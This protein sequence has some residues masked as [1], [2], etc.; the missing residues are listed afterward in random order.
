MKNILLTIVIAL[1][2]SSCS[3]LI[4]KFV[5]KKEGK[6]CTEPACME[7]DKFFWDNFHA[8]NYDSIPRILELLKQSY[9]KNPTDY[10]LAAHIAFTH[11]WAIAEEKKATVSSAQVIDHAS[12]ARQ[13]FKEAFELGPKKDWRLYGF[14]ASFMMIE[15]SIH[16]NDRQATEGYFEM[17]KAVKRYPEF[18]LF[19]KAYSIMDGRRKEA[20]EDLWK[21]LDVCACEKVDRKNLDYRK[22]QGLKEVES[23]MSTCWNNWIAPHNLEGF[24]LIF[25][26]LLLQE[27]DREGALMMYKNASYTDNFD[28]WYYK[29]KVEQRISKLE[30]AIAENRIKAGIWVHDY[31]QCM[32]C[33]QAVEIKNSPKDV[34]LNRP[35]MEVSVHLNK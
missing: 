8:G 12:L 29:G 31:D 7:A 1:V 24:F 28:N 25:G 35:A 32:V 2:V 34:H 14:Y 17:K 33:H 6:L 27:K 5:S 13:Y 21:N 15:G 20:I 23:K 18:N 11:A 10:K 22:Y 16:G 30:N 4:P 19:T 3:T 26:D 9:F